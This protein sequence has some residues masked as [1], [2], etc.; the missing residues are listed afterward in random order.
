MD[1]LWAPWR[2]SYVMESKAEGCIFCSKP[3]EQ[4]DAG[5][6]LLHRGTYCF[7]M[8]NAYPYNN[9]H[10]MVIPY[11]HVSD[12]AALP[13]P[14]AA[15]LMTLT[16]GSIGIL[17]QGLRAAGF[18]VGV[19]MGSAAGAGI[20]DHVHLHIVPRWIGDSNFMT[21]VGATRVLPQS[22]EDTYGLLA[23]QFGADTPPLQ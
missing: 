2:A 22:L 16:Q 18:N 19:N 21:V 11:A 5:N 15:E 9:G 8:L 12:V 1:T 20:A 17:R 7:V 13:P 4:D 10:L 23:P 3:R 6:Y 14:V